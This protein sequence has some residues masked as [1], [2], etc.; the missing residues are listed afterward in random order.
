MIKKRENLRDDV[1]L[2]SVP[3]SP[4]A[5]DPD[6]IR[7]ENA[8]LEFEQLTIVMLPSRRVKRLHCGS[9]SH[10]T[11]GKNCPAKPGRPTVKPRAAPKP[12]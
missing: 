1:R 9:T 7:F 5:N 4:D 10:F 2:V 6:Y 8:G 3:L 12:V 11:Y